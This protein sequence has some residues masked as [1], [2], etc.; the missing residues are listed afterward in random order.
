MAKMFRTYTDENGVTSSCN[1]HAAEDYGPAA[2]DMARYGYPGTA[3]VSP[4]IVE[5]TR[6]R[7]LYRLGRPG[8]MG[9]DGDLLPRA[10]RIPKSDSTETEE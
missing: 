8:A 1:S 10:D 5:D 6:H 9:F 3:P 7:V 2:K 4:N